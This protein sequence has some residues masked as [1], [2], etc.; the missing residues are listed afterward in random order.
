MYKIFTI[1]LSYLITPFTQ[2]FILFTYVVS[3]KVKVI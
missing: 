2:F 3:Q 1:S